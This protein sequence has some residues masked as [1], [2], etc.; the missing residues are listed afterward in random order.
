MARNAV[1]LQR[2]GCPRHQPGQR[3]G[4][5]NKIASDTVGSRTAAAAAAAAG[6]TA[7]ATTAGRHCNAKWSRLLAGY[8][9]SGAPLSF[10]VRFA[11]Y[12]LGRQASMDEGRLSADRHY[13]E[14]VS[15]CLLDLPNNKRE[16]LRMWDV[17][18]EPAPAPTAPK[19]QD[20]GKCNATPSGN[21]LCVSPCKA[22]SSLSRPIYSS[23]R[24]RV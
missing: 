17:G 24:G 12:G 21:C 18:L 9:T 2:V 15:A 11:M 7:T 10:R 5:R 3:E 1:Q 6:A 23:C 14:L 13:C 19:T 22:L 16:S 8:S 20:K 4:R